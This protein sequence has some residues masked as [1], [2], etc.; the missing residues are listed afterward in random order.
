MGF[1]GGWVLD[2]RK[3]LNA[4]EVDLLR[5]DVRGRVEQAGFRRRLPWL[6]WFFVE[7]ALETGL[8]VAEMSSLVC[9]DLVLAVSRP[10][11]LVRC[12]KGGKRRFVRVRRE[13]ANACEDFLAWKTAVGE[14]TASDAPLLVSSRTNTHLTTRA[15]QKMFA[16]ACKRAD[17]TGHS[18]HHARH[19][20]ASF[21]YVASR[22]DLRLVQR[23]LGHASIRTTEVYAH[24]FD[25]DVDDA[26]R[27]LYA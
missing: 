4:G 18:V 20:Y 22:K 2:E 16:R 1:F 23:Q 19:T 25:E 27:K 10:G 15:L 13:F 14:S 17:V 12:G 3:F 7:L 8:R 11:V 9:G 6:E 5:R 24:V 26:M 21:L